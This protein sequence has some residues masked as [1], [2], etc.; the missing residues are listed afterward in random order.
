MSATPRVN[1]PYR[2]TGPKC[3]GGVTRT[4]SG[5][6]KVRIS[7]AGKER[8]LGCYA[9]QEEAMRVKRLADVEHHKHYAD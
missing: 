3:R 1:R 5:T 7:I 8:Y 4:R 2:K 6:W 9:T